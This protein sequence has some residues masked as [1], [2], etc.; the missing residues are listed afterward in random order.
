MQNVVPHIQFLGKLLEEVVLH[1]VLSLTDQLPHRKLR[2]LKI[3]IDAT[4]REHKVRW[5]VGTGQKGLT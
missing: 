1:E 3:E 2:V 5:W 4:A